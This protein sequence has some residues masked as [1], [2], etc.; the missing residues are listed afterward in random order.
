MYNS[1]IVLKGSESF[2]HFSIDKKTRFFGTINLINLIIK[3]WK[4]ADFFTLQN[5]YRSRSDAASFE[6]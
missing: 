2:F 1:K 4:K 3:E 6:P 5:L